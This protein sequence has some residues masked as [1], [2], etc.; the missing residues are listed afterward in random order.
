[1]NVP[2]VKLKIGEIGAISSKIEEVLNFLLQRFEEHDQ[3]LNK[4]SKQSKYIHS[5][6]GLMWSLIQQFCKVL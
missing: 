4:V 2:Q 1:M 6:L 5:G 3:R